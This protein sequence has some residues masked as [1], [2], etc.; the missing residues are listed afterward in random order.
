MVK[1][2]PQLSFRDI[3]M[4]L[5]ETG[6]RTYTGENFKNMRQKFRRGDIEGDQSEEKVK[7]RQEKK[8]VSKPKEKSKRKH[9]RGKQ[10]KRV[11]RK[12]ILASMKSLFGE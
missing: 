2:S 4:K 5:R 3:I 9:S 10:P 8:S 6:V 11:E 12:A 1:A 7:L